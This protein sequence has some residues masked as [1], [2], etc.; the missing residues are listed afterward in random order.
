[1]K[2]PARALLVAQTAAG[3]G[4]ASCVPEVEGL[5]LVGS[6]VVTAVVRA[7][8][9]AGAAARPWQSRRQAL[10]FEAPSM[11]PPAPR[12]PSPPASPGT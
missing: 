11:T 10:L 2:A 9:A 3:T 8:E 1:V 4:L 5:V 12:R 7:L 6:S